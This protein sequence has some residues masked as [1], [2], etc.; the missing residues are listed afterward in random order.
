MCHHGA[1]SIAI[2]VAAVACGGAVA[3]DRQPSDG[4]PPPSTSGCPAGA[5]IRSGAAVGAACTP[6][7]AYCPEPD[8]DPCTMACRA[9]SCAQG[10]WAKALN[11]ADCTAGVDA[12]VCVEIDPTTF[13]QS[14]QMD[15]DCLAIAAGTFCSGMPPCFCPFAVINADGDGRYQALIQQAEQL[16]APTHGCFCPAS[17][18][19]RCIQGSC[20]LCGGAS[21]SHAGCPDGG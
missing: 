5:D 12:A 10:A 21:P 3:A 6:E 18:A 1:L 8:C 20:A 17:G 14:C 16:A 11:T 15:R 19:P 2:A 4:G 7:G 9:V 13:D